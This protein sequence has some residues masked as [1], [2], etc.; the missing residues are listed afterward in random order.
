M[1]GRKPR[2]QL[3][4]EE[5]CRPLLGGYHGAG[6]QLLR[7]AAAPTHP[8]TAKGDADRR[9]RAV[10]DGRLRTSMLTGL[11]DAQAT[12][13]AR[14]YGA[15]ATGWKDYAR[16]TEML[17]PP[18]GFGRAKAEKSGQNMPLESRRLP[19]EAPKPW[20]RPHQILSDSDGGTRRLQS[21]AVPSLEETVREKELLDQQEAAERRRAIEAAGQPQDDY[22]EDEEEM[23]DGAL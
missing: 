13:P 11:S 3:M 2:D 4:E 9:E 19:K 6:T 8:P 20:R 17:S 10:R 22:W 12:G 1:R 7:S 5:L 21:F 16:E 18:P 15:S 14:P 23:E